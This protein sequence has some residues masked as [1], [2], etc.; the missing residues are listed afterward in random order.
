MAQAGVQCVIM[1]VSSHAIALDRVYGLNF[2]LAVFSNLTRDHLDFHETLDNYKRAKFTLFDY[3]TENDGVAVVNIDDHYGKEL[4]DML[5]CERK[6]V[7]FEHGHY[8]IDK[9]S[10][11][12]LGCEFELR[13]NDQSE[14]YSINFI[15]KHNM[16]NTAL[17]I[18]A[19]KE[20]YDIKLHTLQE[21]LQH[22]NGVDRQARAHRHG[23]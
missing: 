21:A 4:F 3:L 16:L 19:I 20:S 11:S 22:I 9:T 10:S 6:S 1:E 15:G 13:F 5:E 23:Q 12:I 2:D 17:A 18:A 14:P 7:S 8:M